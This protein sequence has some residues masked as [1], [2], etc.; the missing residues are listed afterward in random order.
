MTEPIGKAVAIGVGCHWKAFETIAIEV[1]LKE[2]LI[3][4]GN[5]FRL[6]QPRSRLL[7]NAISVQLSNA[8]LTASSSS[9]T[10][11]EHAVAIVGFNDANAVPITAKGIGEKTIILI[12]KADSISGWLRT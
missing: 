6:A 7:K 11:L 5:G 9:L 8:V 10:D 4:L 12:F 3:A 1:K 2:L